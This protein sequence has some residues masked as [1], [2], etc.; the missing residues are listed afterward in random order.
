M[1]ES[2][3]FGARQHP[4]HRPWRGPVRTYPSLFA[5]G[6]HNAVA[7]DMRGSIWLQFGRQ[8]TVHVNAT[9]CQPRLAT[10][11]QNSERSA[12]RL[13][14]RS[15]SGATPRLAAFQRGEDVVVRPHLPA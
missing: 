3:E 10:A 14:A 6:R 12:L 2:A 11:R 1:G 15:S 4:R 7:E 5:R 13:I 9:G 8:S